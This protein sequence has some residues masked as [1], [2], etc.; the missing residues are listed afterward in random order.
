MKNKRVRR[1][2][3]WALVIT[4]AGLIFYF[5]SMNGP[6]S[7]EISDGFTFWFMRLF[8]PDM[9]AMA[10]EEQNRIYYQFAFFV[11]KAAHFTE[12]AALGLSLRLLV[13][14]YNLRRGLLWAWVIGTLYAGTDE[15]HQA[16]VAARG[17]SLRDVGID[18]SGVFFGALMVGFLIYL[19][20]IIKRKRIENKNFRAK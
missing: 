8:Y 9:E 7:L 5:S 18:S 10:L 4:V 1:M 12:F 17:P 3:L 16:F 20:G 11:R 14:E 6:E 2:L 13:R 19:L 15:L